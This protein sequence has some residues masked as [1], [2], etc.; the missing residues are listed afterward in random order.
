M[1]SIIL[2]IMFVC[3]QP[4][5][6]IVKFPDNP[7]PIMTHEVY[8]PDIQD[9]LGDIIKAKPIIIPYEDDRGTCA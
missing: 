1:E 9:A 3:G 4:D 8:N 6:I 7:N 2:I 5:T